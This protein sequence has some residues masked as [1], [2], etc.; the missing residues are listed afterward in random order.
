MCHH[1]V[2][3]PLSSQVGDMVLIVHSFLLESIQFFSSWK[4]DSLYCDPASRCR[5]TI[6]LSPHPNDI[7]VRLV[8]MSVPCQTPTLIVKDAFL[9]QIVMRDVSTNQKFSDQFA[10][11]A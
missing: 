5:A 7:R 3:T 11:W 8:D 2:K 10:V 6:E 4:K 9:T 1:Q